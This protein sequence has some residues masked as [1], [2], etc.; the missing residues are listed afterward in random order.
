MT[1]SRLPTEN[2]IVTS[3][4]AGVNARNSEGA[5]YFAVLTAPSFSTPRFKPA[6]RGQA[7]ARLAQ[8]LDR[9]F[10]VGQKLQAGGREMDAAPDVLEQRH[11]DLCFEQL[12]LL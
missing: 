4:N 7:L 8:Q 12:E 11:A 6:H 3:G 10:R 1:S 2:L 9:L 5:K